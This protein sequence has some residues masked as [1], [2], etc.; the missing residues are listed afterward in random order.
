MPDS[1]FI[2]SDYPVAMEIFDINVP[3]NRIVPL[4]P[5]LAIRIVPDIRLSRTKPDLTFAK[6]RSVTRGL[7]R[8]EVLQ[9][10]RLLVRCA[11]ELV[12]FR[13]DLDW[14]EG[15]IM[16]NCHYRIKSVTKKI[17]RGSGNILV[18]TYRVNAHREDA[19]I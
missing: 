13:D 17:S 18:S 1:P 9:I 11:E 8:P 3:I 7:K 4:A 10:N 14:I 19:R 2:T 16:K 6:F 5:D 15:F 12:F